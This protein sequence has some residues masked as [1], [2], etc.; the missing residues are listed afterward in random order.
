MLLSEVNRVLAGRAERSD[1]QPTREESDLLR[2]YNE[3]LIHKLEQKVLQ[4]EQANQGLNEEIGRRERAA[5]ELK[6]SEE[7][8]RN[9]FEGINDPLFVY[10][11]STWRYLMVNRAAVEKYGY[12]REEFMS[13]TIMDLRPPE[14]VQ[15]LRDSL[16]QHPGRMEHR[17]IWRHRKKNGEI[18]DVQIATH[19]LQFE[20]KSAGL[21]EARDITNER[22]AEAEVARTSR[23]LRAVIDGTSDAV[24]VK[25][26]QGTY[27]LCNEAAARFLGRSPADIVGKR[28]TDPFRPS[29]SL[30]IAETDSLTMES[31]RAFTAE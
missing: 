14:D 29:Y 11:T 5:V 7:R 27:L 9:L 22:R 13:M 4:L 30:I 24:F 6:N 28:D 3:V 12:T 15:K 16:A 21:A 23:I 1:M 31:D 8:Y 25:D 20:G 26:Q 10:D 18:V 19:P 17:G 2:E